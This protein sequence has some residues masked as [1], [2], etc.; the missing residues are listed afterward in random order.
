MLNVPSAQ[1]V[2]LRVTPLGRW[3]IQEHFHGIG[4]C[5]QGYF[6]VRQ[7]PIVESKFVHP[8]FEF[9]SFHTAAD[10]QDRGFGCTTRV[11]VGVVDNAG[12]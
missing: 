5:Q 8:A 4:H 2:S 9:W 1:Q 6:I 12:C 11:A 3:Q 10:L 7:R